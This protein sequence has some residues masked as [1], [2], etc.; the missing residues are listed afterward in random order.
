M[1]TCLK[2]PGEGRG[3][4][5][6]QG[7]PLEWVCGYTKGEETLRM[8]KRILMAGAD[9]NIH[10]FAGDNLT[11]L[12]NALFLH[13]TAQMK[14]LLE[15]GAKREMSCQRFPERS[16]DWYAQQIDRD[17]GLENTPRSLMRVLQCY[18]RSPIGQFAHTSLAA[19]IQNN[20]TPSSYPADSSEIALPPAPPA[21]P[22]WSAALWQRYAGRKS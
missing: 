20:A 3:S 6:L 19:A 15:Y 22:S 10:F 5:P 14:L 17:H 2:Q 11:P 9:P 1:N 8:M 21:R 16:A 12:I 4:G 18:G 13:S 7:W